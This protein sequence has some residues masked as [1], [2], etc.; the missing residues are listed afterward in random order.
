MLFSNGVLISAVAAGLFSFPAPL[1]DET[2]MV[3]LQ[4]VVDSF[5]GFLDDPFHPSVIQT[6]SW[7][8]D[9]I[10]LHAT[11]FKVGFEASRHEP[12]WFAGFYPATDLTAEAFSF[13]AGHRLDA[14]QAKSF[15]AEKMRAGSWQLTEPK[16]IFHIE[17]G[18]LVS[19]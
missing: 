15:F 8:W 11:K 1:V 9:G 18:E 17:N 4:P 19:W 13:S 16:P 5:S 3:R 6:G 10:E 14:I 7:Q 12:F 2:H